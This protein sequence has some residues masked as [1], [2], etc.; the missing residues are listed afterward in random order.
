MRTPGDWRDMVS[1]IKTTSREAWLIV[2]KAIKVIIGIILV[3]WLI[4]SGFTLDTIEFE[5]LLILLYFW[6]YSIYKSIKAK[7]GK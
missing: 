4:L 3:L 2:P 7:W 5:L 6:F 1:E